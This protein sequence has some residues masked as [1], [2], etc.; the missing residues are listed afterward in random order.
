MTSTH[1]YSLLAVSDACYDEIVRRLRAAG[2]HNA[3]NLDDSIALHGIA[4]ARGGEPGPTMTVAYTAVY[5]ANL[6][7]WAT[8]PVADRKRCVAHLCRIMQDDWP[9]AYDHMRAGV[10]RGEQIGKDWVDFHFGFGMGVRNVLRQVMLDDKLPLVDGGRNWDDYY[11]G[12]L[13]EMCRSHGG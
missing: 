1:S 11:L 9:E 6:E 12:A 3:V 4:L 7:N 10:A 5:A 8:V 13:D 2:I